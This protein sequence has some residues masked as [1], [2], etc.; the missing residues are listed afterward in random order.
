MARLVKWLL[1]ANLAKHRL[2]FQDAHLVFNDES[3][4]VEDERY[5][6]DEARLIWYIIRTCGHDHRFG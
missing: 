4:F 2:D 3:F 6:Y 5:Q 1:G